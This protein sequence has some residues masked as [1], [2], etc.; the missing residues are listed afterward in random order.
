MDR[1][2]ETEALALSSLVTIN[3]DAKL[4][5]EFSPVFLTHYQKLKGPGFFQFYSVGDQKRLRQSIQSPQASCDSRLSESYAFEKLGKRSYRT[6]QYPF[7]PELDEG[8]P[9][10]LLPARPWLCLV[11]GIDQAPYRT[12]VLGTIL[13]TAPI[14]IG[15]LFV[16]LIVLLVLVRSLTSDLSRLGVA[17]ESADFSATHAFPAF[18]EVTTAEVSAITEKLETLHSQAAQVYQ[19]MWLFLGRAAHQ[20][21]TPM[22]AL[23]STLEVLLR[24]ERSKE[25]WLAGVTDI[26]DAVAQMVRLTKQLL[27]SSQASYQPASD[28]SEKRAVA[29]G[30]FFSDLIKLFRPQAELKSIIFQIDGSP[31]LEVLGDVLSLCELFSNL[32]DNAIRYSPVNRIVFISWDQ[33]GDRAL[34]SIRD[35]GAG[36]SEGMRNRL[37]E[38]FVRGDERQGQGSGLG[39]SIAKRAAI[40]LNGDVVLSSTG[41]FGSTIA[42]TLP[43][44]GEP[45]GG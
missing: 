14:L 27:A 38:P 32:L 9:E 23:Q 25:E 17:L 22:T 29:L 12:L 2:L 34:I 39:L 28:D 11:V 21:K 31:K 10:T 33:N 3:S 44:A 37:F 41:I 30:K 7:R 13:S 19:E 42:V 18:P 20:L 35:E 16:S 40:L 8:V 43:T 36:F 5:F 24:K 26:Q 6:L 1:L 4:D 45:A 15:I